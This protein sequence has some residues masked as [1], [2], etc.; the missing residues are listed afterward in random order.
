MNASLRDVLLHC[1]RW[2]GLS[3]G[4]V[5]LMIALT[6]AS[7]VFRPQLDPLV[8]GNL[9][10]VPTCIERLSLDQLTEQA[11]AIHPGAVPE[12]IEL[13]AGSV[14]EARM[15]SATVRFNDQILVFLNPCNAAVIGQ[16]HRYGGWFGTMEQLHRF[17]FMENGSLLGGSCVLLFGLLLVIGGL[18]MWWPEHLRSLKSA[19]RF[20]PRVVGVARSTSL[21]KSIGPYVSLILLTS[22]LSGLPQAFEWYAH[23]LYWMAGAP[24]AAKPPRSN[25]RENTTSSSIDAAWQRAQSLVPQV[26]NAVLRFPRKQG[27]AIEIIL[28]DSQARHPNARTLLY[29]DATTG[30]VLRFIPYDDSSAGHQLF[31]WSLSL[32]TGQVGGLFA[33]LLLLSGALSVPLLA[34]TGISSYLLRRR[35]NRYSGRLSVKVVRKVSEAIDQFSLE[36]VDVKG[37]ALPVFSAGSYVDVILRDGTVRQY[38]LCNPPWETHRYQLCILHE[39]D[40]EGAARAL[41]DGIKRGSVIQISPPVARFELD[42]LARQSILIASGIGIAPILCMAEQLASLGAPFVLHYCAQSEAQTA[43]LSRL[44]NSPFASSVH[45]H[46]SNGPPDQLID[47]DQIFSHPAPDSHSYVCGPVGFLNVV[48]DSA[49]EHAW[50]K[51][52]VHKEYFSSPADLRETDT[53]FDI[54]LARSGKVLRVQKYQTVLEVLSANGIDVPRTCERGVCGTC[55]TRVLAGRPAHRDHYLTPEE[56]RRNDQFTP[57]CSRALEDL[58]VLDL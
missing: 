39:P 27:D 24:P 16:R 56:H 11:I 47:L 58:L 57:C 29:L 38:F 10:R 54:R 40:S 18:A 9:L 53:A 48:T 33:Q 43:F 20:N 51:Y 55:L 6:G 13:T 49:K 25:W 50:P 8:N 3:V 36:L 1:H 7:L 45:F 17:R 22:V 52:R 4:L 37:R 44:K 35:R 12:Q 15:P 34:F 23:G 5:M 26:R 21:H 19:L 30:E 31:Y 28:I 41:H 46:F 32:H 42:P 14:G 2:A